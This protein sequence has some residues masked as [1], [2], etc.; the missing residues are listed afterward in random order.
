VTNYTLLG[1]LLRFDELILI[2]NQIKSIALI[3]SGSRWQ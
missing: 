2:S 3:I 1:V